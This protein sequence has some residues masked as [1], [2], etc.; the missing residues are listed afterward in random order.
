MSDRAGVYD[1]YSKAADL[2]GE[3]QS[4]LTTPNT[5]I[6][7]SW[8]PDGQTLV[9]YELTTSGTQR[10]IWT[11]AIGS[12]PVSFLATTFNERAP[13]L[14]S[15]GHWL[16]YVSDQSGE[17]RVYV[18]RFPEGGRIIS[19]S[20]GRGTE[21]VWSRDGRELFYRNGNQML[22]VEVHTGPAFAVGPPTLL[23]EGP[24]DTDP[25]AQANPNYDV[26]PDRADFLM[27][28]SGGAGRTLG[29]IVVLNWFEELKRLVPV[30]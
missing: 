17:N 24:Y 12:D 26:S 23:F 30:P 15:D 14:S 21:P 9:Y 29:L 18:Q 19:V 13:R 16:A 7:G 10:D 3:A 6:P 5:K 2:S 11:L 28:R 1:L 25:N 27:V 22:V 8:S 4:L 20:T